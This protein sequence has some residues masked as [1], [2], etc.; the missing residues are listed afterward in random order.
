MALVLWSLYA[1]GARSMSPKGRG[2]RGPN[3]ENWSSSVEKMEYFTSEPDPH[4]GYGS[5]LGS[6]KRTSGTIA[7]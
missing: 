6:T 4:R 1:V 7:E 2:S 5:T 3:C